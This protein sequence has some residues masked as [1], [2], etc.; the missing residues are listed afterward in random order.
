MN[1]LETGVERSVRDRSQKTN[2][3]TKWR[4]DDDETNRVQEECC[5]IQKWKNCSQV[6]TFCQAR[7]EQIQQNEVP[8]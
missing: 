3:L 5:S 6:F 2:T 4:Q 8:E 1:K 7:S